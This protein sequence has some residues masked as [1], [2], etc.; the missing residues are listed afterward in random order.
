MRIMAAHDQL[1]LDMD[2]RDG[3]CRTE[4]EVLYVL[5]RDTLESRRIADTTRIRRSRV[6]RTERDAG[7]GFVS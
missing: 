5:S 1:Y 6:Y 3:I 4:A 2:R 7:P